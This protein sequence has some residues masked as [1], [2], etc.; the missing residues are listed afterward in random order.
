MALIY[1]RVTS[2]RPGQCAASICRAPL[3][4]YATAAGKAMPMKR[5][6]QPTSTAVDPS[7]LLVIGAFDAAD[8]HWASC[9]ARARFV[10]ASTARR[11]P[12]GV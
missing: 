2:R 12:R 4:W 9:P 10:G 8:S 6:A 7:S 5:G 11:R 1:L 3:D